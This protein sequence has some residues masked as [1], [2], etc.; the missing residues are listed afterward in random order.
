[1]PPKPNKKLL[2]EKITII[3]NM[4]AHVAA[5]DKACKALIQA[6]NEIPAVKTTLFALFM[7]HIEKY[8]AYINRLK[9]PEMQ[10]ILT[11]KDKEFIAYFSLRIGKGYQAYGDLE[12]ARACYND[13]IGQDLFAWTSLISIETCP[14]R[15][16]GL[17]ESFLLDSC[18]PKYAGQIAAFKETLFD[19]A[20]KLL[21]TY[22]QESSPDIKPFYKK[23][24]HI[25]GGYGLERI[26]L[27]FSNPLSQEATFWRGILFQHLSA[28]PKENSIFFTLDH[29]VGLQCEYYVDNKKY[30]ELFNLLDKHYNFFT[31]Q[32]VF[33]AATTLLTEAP[34]LPHTALKKAATWLTDARLQ[35]LVESQL[36]HFFE[37][38][39]A[40]SRLFDAE[41][42]LGILEKAL[43]SKDKNISGPAQA[44]MGDLHYNGY[45]GIPISHPKALAHYL[46]ASESGITS[47]LPKIAQMHQLGQGTPVNLTAALYFYE[48]AHVQGDLSAAA[49][50]WHQIML[51]SITSYTV[52]ERSINLAKG[53]KFINETEV[54]ILDFMKHNTCPEAMNE[55]R[56]KLAYQKA[57]NLIY[58]KSVDGIQTLVPKTD[59][60]DALKILKI[61]SLDNPEALE[62]LQ[63]AIQLGSE[64]TQFRAHHQ[65]GHHYFCTSDFDK[66]LSA[67]QQ[68]IAANKASDNYDP[69]YD[70]WLLLLCSTLLKLQS[71]KQTVLIDKTTLQFKALNYFQQAL[72]IHEEDLPAELQKVADFL[73]K[74]NTNIE[75]A[76]K[77]V[78]SIFQLISTKFQAHSSES[79][80]DSAKKLKTLLSS[81]STAKTPET[82]KQVSQLIENINEHLLDDTS[83]LPLL[84][85]F[86]SACVANAHTWKE[87][88]IL[89]VFYAVGRWHLT[90]ATAALEPLLLY[91]Q[92]HLT[93]MSFERCAKY[94]KFIAQ[95]NFTRDA[96]KNNEGLLL[97]IFESE[98]FKKTLA[99]E[100]FTGKDAARLFYGLAL[101]DCNRHHPLYLSLAEQIF[102]RLKA[103][104]DDL[105]P[106]EVS[107]VY[108]AYHYFSSH[109]NVAWYKGSLKPIF[110]EK[111]EATLCVDVAAPSKTQQKIFQH[112]QKLYPNTLHERFIKEAG[113]RVDFVIDGIIIQYNGARKHYV[114]DDDGKLHRSLK[115]RLAL[116]TLK[117]VVCIDRAEW[118]NLGNDPEA[119]CRYLRNLVETAKAKMEKRVHADE[120]EDEVIRPFFM[121]VGREQGFM[122]NYSGSEEKKAAFV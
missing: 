100:S 106:Y 2:Q 8:T 90:S 36:N 47:V 98:D 115:E 32:Q 81:E 13:V 30:S 121:R 11:E 95:C 120:D 6:E 99:A 3:A 93:K 40:H 59:N 70:F 122:L 15:L 102:K 7:P 78:D 58:Q 64:E 108:H 10:R 118:N 34:N 74:T 54:R 82:L 33:L 68:A 31:A 4:R 103:N 77:T 73:Y 94:I 29:Y 28:N 110:F 56:A 65:L 25:L 44:I 97:K 9:E 41:K 1:M 75:S 62:A 5:F 50:S 57:L 87:S 61:T 63:V 91:L 26:S 66:A 17:R 43:K 86:V 84:G 105:G 116:K 111:Y 89:D 113:R 35:S 52:Q 107:E 119:E 20:K 114:A 18:Q 79:W 92:P 38:F 83:L 49:L 88:E 21:E 51:Q 23:Y 27:S 37:A 22:I 96:Q 42:S 39:A 45:A 117:Q 112:L 67:F 14:I 12:S 109:H 55:F 60:R 71:E 46:K 53:L 16:K 104:N 24:S 80:D 101:L 19:N 48:Q 69:V 72:N 85:Q 76:Q